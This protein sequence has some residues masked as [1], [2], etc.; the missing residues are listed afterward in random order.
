MK[1]LKTFETHEEY[2]LYINGENAYL[3]NVSLTL[4]DNTIHF[5]DYIPIQTDPYKYLTIEALEDDFIVWIEKPVEDSGGLM[6]LRQTN[7]I[8]EGELLYCID[9]DNIWYNYEFGT[10][11]PTINK[12]QTISFKGLLNTTVDFQGV[13]IFY[14]N[15]KKFNLKGNCLSIIF[16]DDCDK[17][18]DLTNYNYCFNNLFSYSLVVN[19]SKT[20]LPATTLADNC[21]GYMFSDCIYLT[22]APDLPATTLAF[23]CYNAMFNNCESLTI[24]PSLPATTLA[25]SCYNNMF[26]NCISLTT[27]PELPA[28]TLTDYCYYNMFN[29]CTSLTTAPEL[30]ATELASCYYDTMF[31]NCSKLNYIK[32]MFTTPIKGDATLYGWVSG[33]ASTGTFVKNKNAARTWQ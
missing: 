17:N 32:A 9:N 30:P 29:G 26:Q 2:D 27:A 25:G 8:S 13:C 3:P 4:D 5:L 16:G 18:F 22:T 20:F 23:D 19:I 7:N 15:D 31:A 1:Y 11:T 10:D 33:V 24:A 12:G 28:T 21:Y 6:S 14:T